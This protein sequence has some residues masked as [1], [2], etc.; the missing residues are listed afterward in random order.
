M[1]ENFFLPS[2]FLTAKIFSCNIILINMFSLVYN[3]IMNWPTNEKD[4]KIIGF[5]YQNSVKKVHCLY[6]FYIKVHYRRPSDGYNYFLPIMWFQRDGLTCQTTRGEFGK[7]FI[8]CLGPFNWSLS[9]CDL[10][11]PAKLMLV[12]TG[13]NLQRWTFWKPI[14]KDLFVKY[15]LICCLK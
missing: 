5:Y 3:L 8:S 7:Q 15:R 11:W 6:F 2:V 13:T 1:L 4:L 9:M 10:T 12:A 14:L